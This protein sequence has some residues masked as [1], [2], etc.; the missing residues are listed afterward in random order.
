MYVLIQQKEKKAH[1]GADQET[2]IQPQPPTPENLAAYSETQEYSGETT[3]NPDAD[4][5]PRSDIVV[6]TSVGLGRSEMGD[7]DRGK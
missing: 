5:E 3:E 4:E 2:I 7:H 6:S 1:K